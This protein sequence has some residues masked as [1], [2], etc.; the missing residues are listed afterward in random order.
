[1][2]CTDAFLECLW[3]DFNTG[4]SGDYALHIVLNDCGDYVV[5]L[6]NVDDL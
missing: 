2:P 5:T 1:M 3:W 6:I 4:V